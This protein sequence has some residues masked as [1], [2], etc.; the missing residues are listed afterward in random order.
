MHKPT[1]EILGELQYN[2]ILPTQAESQ[3]LLHFCFPRY[4][5]LS[6]KNVDKSRYFKVELSVF[7]F[8]GENKGITGLQFLSVC[9]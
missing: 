6:R 8:S 7:S 9:K 3:L 4:C 1:S 2:V 5:P